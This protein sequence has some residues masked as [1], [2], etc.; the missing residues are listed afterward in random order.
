M[1]KRLLFGTFLLSAMLAVPVYAANTNS[2]NTGEETTAAAEEYSYDPT[3]EIVLMRNPDGEIYGVPKSVADMM[4]EEGYSEYEETTTAEEEVE[5]SVIY[6]T[7]SEE[8]YQDIRDQIANDTDYTAYIDVWTDAANLIIPADILQLLNEN[9][10]A[11]SISF[12]D[13]TYKNEKENE[14]PIPKQKYTIFIMGDSSVTT[15]ENIDLTSSFDETDTGYTFNSNANTT[16]NGMGMMIIYDRK[17]GLAPTGCY[18]MTDNSGNTIGEGTVENSHGIWINL[19]TMRSGT[20]VK[21]ADIPETEDYVEETEEETKEES[22]SE[23]KTVT[24]ESKSAEEL[25]NNV[26]KTANHTWIYVVAAC[27]CGVL[28][29]ARYYII[30]KKKKI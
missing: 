20:A 27:I 12:F 30:K 15:N 10:G 16:L 1:K 26:E 4:K 17:D 11:L 13:K 6:D 9:D 7:A 14:S 22:T 5:E 28:G 2:K 18:T 8:M 19:S 21:T 29:G 25:T 23:A 3:E 24:E